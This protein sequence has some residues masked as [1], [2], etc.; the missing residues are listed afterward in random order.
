MLYVSAVAKQLQL[1]YGKSNLLATSSH[2]ANSTIV[3]PRNPTNAVISI[4]ARPSVWNLKNSGLQAR[5][6]TN[7]MMYSAIGLENNPALRY[8]L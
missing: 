7:W 4:E 5:F 2:F 3:A 1:R 8:T 6:S